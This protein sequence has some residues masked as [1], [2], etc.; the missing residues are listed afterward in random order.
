MT[1]KQ[2]NAPTSPSHEQKRPGMATGAGSAGNS[3]LPQSPAG[4]PKRKK[5]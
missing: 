3:N 5:E 1:K 4:E 2:N